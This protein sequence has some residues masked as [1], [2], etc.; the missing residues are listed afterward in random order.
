MSPPV[1]D[2]FIG[3]RQRRIENLGALKSRGIDPYPAQSQKDEQNA[4]VIQ[5]YS[6]Y[7][8][9]TLSLTGRLNNARSMGKIIFMDLHDASGRI[10]VCV[11]KDAYP[12]SPTHDTANLRDQTLTWDELAFLDTGDFVQAEGMISKTNS[13]EITLFASSIKILAKTIRPL[14]NTIERKEDRFRRRYLDLL[15]HPELRELFVRKATFWNTI[16]QTLLAKGFTEVF[17]PVLEHTTGG[18]DAR[19]FVTHHNSLGED[20]YLRI[21]LELF[22]KRCIGAGFEKVFSIGPVFR[23]EGASD[24]HANEF[25]HIE[26]YWAY[27]DYRDQMKLTREVMIAAA[28]SVYGKT[29]FHSRGHTFDLAGDWSEIDYGLVIKERF[30]IDVFTSS[31]DEIRAIL[32]NE[33]VAIEGAANRQR[34]VD[35]LWKIIRKTIAG[36]A[37]LVN[38]PAFMSP[39]SKPKKENPR[40][41]ERFHVIIAGTE[42]A[43]GYSEINDPRYQL[44]QFLLQ[45]KM[46]DAGD[47]EAQ[48]LDIDFVEMLEYGMPPTAGIG[49]SERYFWFL[50]DI[51]AREGTMFPILRREVDPLTKKIYSEVSFASSNASS[52]NRDPSHTTP[53]LEDHNQSIAPQKGAA[54]GS[55]ALL[56]DSPPPS[57]P[58]IPLSRKQALEIVHGHI[59]N[60]GLIKHCL[61]VEAAM[62]AVFEYFFSRYPQKH[63]GHTEKI[64]WTL[65]GLLHDA[66]WEVCKNDI[67][68]HTRKTVEWIKESAGDKASDQTLQTLT[69]AILSHNFQ[70]NGEPPPA[71]TLEWSLICCD[72]LTGLIIATALVQPGK[73]LADV[74]VESVLKKMHSKSFAAG[75]DRKQIMMCEDKLGIPLPEFIAIVL[76]GM[77]KY[78]DALGL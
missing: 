7:E 55:H 18:A 10:Q 40:F 52:E 64:V 43:N 21:S 50:E 37:F 23:N 54:D 2:D 63:H 34:L 36:P 17:L 60:R 22:S 25:M 62:E 48:M 39:L 33:G 4:V 28:S 69:R 26:W 76:H 75:V 30:G 77:Q 73:K 41:A 38:E 57:A 8:K 59:S 70:H 45:Q 35:N 65:A 46:R 66:D 47:D 20:L 44:E 3:Q 32:K 16:R 1:S 49:F 72:E 56:P 53:K 74:T 58:S 5:H 78:A 42:L 19:P 31:E 13:G 51:S 24:E 6:R 61:A 67:T 29:K 27:A 68:Q 71:N 11:K 14:P 15:K 12:Q 9:K